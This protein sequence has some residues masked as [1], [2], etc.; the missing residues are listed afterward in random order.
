[1]EKGEGGVKGAE[2]IVV[3]EDGEAF[4]PK[5]TLETFFSI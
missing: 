3:G 5:N 1:M 4:V 2:F